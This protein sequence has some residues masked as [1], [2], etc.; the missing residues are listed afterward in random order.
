MIPFFMATILSDQD[1]VLDI[2]RAWKIQPDPQDTGETHGWFRLNF[3]DKDWQ[4]IDAG[5]TLEQEGL[6]NFQG[7]LWYRKIFQLP[8]TWQGK[9]VYLAIG[10][11][12]NAYKCFLNGELLAEYSGEIAESRVLIAL[13][14]LNFNMPN[15][16]AFKVHCEDH[17]GGLVHR[18]YALALNRESLGGLVYPLYHNWKFKCDPHNQGIKEGWSSPDLSDEDWHILQAGKSWEEQGFENYDGIGWFRK[19]FRLPDFWGEEPV[20]FIFGGVDDEYELFVNGK[21]VAKFGDRHRDHSVHATT[22]MTDI[23]PYIRRQA[24]NVVALR[25]VDWGGG[26]GLTRLPVQ[27]VSLKKQPEVSPSA[28]Y[29]LEKIKDKMPGPI[30]QKN[31]EWVELYWKAWEIGLKKIKKPTIFNG[32]V[33]EYMDEAFSD[34]IFQWDTCFMVLFGRYAWHVIPAVQSLDNFYDKQ[35][36]DG[37]ICREIRESDGTNYWDKHLSKDTINP[38]LFAWVEWKS[39]LLSGD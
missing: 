35:D 7:T 10:G 8:K 12:K 27:I 28:G 4:V 6:E 2:S 13:K 19:T 9:T 33:S 26:G 14:K 38:P 5:R 31:P 36:A 24:L 32:F 15:I 37:F 1:E 22:T 39:Y 11:I 17:Y 30:L 25:V 23:T 21:K 29:T 18:P 16:L 3:N 34:N 20:H